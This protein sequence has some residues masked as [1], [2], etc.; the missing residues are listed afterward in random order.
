MSEIKFKMR[1][2]LLCLLS[3]VAYGRMT[4]GE[5]LDMRNTEELQKLLEDPSKLDGV[6]HQV[7]RDRFSY[8]QF[9]GKCNRFNVAAQLYEKDDQGK[10]DFNKPIQNEMID[11][12]LEKRDSR[13]QVLS[14][15]LCFQRGTLDY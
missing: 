12:I 15:F 5:C 6:W 11:K 7:K 8:F 14:L 1:N 4:H 9:G 2:F 3:T 10:K 13:L